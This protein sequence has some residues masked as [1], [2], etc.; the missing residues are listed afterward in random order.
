M[1][2]V[3]VKMDNFFESWNNDTFHHRLQVFLVYISPVLLLFFFLIIFYL[4]NGYFLGYSN[5]IAIAGYGMIALSLAIS[6]LIKIYPKSQLF[7]FIAVQ[8]KGL[9]MAA[10]Y[11][12]L[13]HVIAQPLVHVQD[14]AGLEFVESQAGVIVFGI[15]A[16]TFM[17][18]LALTS[19]KFSIKKMGFKNWKKLQRPAMNIVLW[20][21][22]IHIIFAEAYVNIAGF[23]IV[24]VLKLFQI[25]YFDIKNRKSK[26]QPPKQVGA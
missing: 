7:Q 26:S 18:L 12:F 25:Y 2:S 16:F 15:I 19:N 5:H 1:N 24:I 14:D 21:T 9:G 23:S 20:G 10:F 11:T 4:I 8:R 13:F 17:C 6:P 22:F 3:L